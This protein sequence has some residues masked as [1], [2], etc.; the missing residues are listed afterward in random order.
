MQARMELGATAGPEELAWACQVRQ[1]SVAAFLKA[2]EVQPPPEHSRRKQQEPEGG[3]L[4]PALGEALLKKG[5]AVKQGNKYYRL[6]N[7]KSCT[8]EVHKPPLTRL[9]ITDHKGQK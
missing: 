6:W 3:P 2:R 4:D 5:Q 1:G 8:T 7:G 9:H